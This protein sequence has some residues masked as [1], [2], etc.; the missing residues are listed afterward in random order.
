[1]NLELKTQ[2]C[3]ACNTE[4]IWALTPKG[5]RIPLD[6]KSQVYRLVKGLDGETR[7]ERDPGAFVSHFQTCP[8]ANRFSKGGKNG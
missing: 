4:M 2:K 7:A 3:K 6:S 5:K 8:D 1:M